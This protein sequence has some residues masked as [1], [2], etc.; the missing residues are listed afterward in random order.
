MIKIDKISF[1]NTIN[2]VISGSKFSGK[3]TLAKHFARMF[4]RNVVY[5]PMKDF[6]KA[7]FENIYV[8]NTN[9]PEEYEIFCANVLRVGNMMMIVDEAQNF[10]PGGNK[11]L[12]PSAFQIVMHGRHNGIGLMTTTKRPALLSKTVFEEANY[13]F[14]FRHMIPNDI[15]YLQEIVGEDAWI[16]QYLNNYRFMIYNNSG[17]EQTGSFSGPY[18]LVGDRIIEDKDDKLNQDMSYIANIAEECIS[19]LRKK[20]VKGLLSRAN[21]DVFLKIKDVNLLPGTADLIYKYANTM[22]KS[23]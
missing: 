9:M 20:G 12:T 18:M 11:L 14:L 5:D 22:S 2:I 23:R 19:W 3:S 4:L 10:M 6:Q 21:V 7:G 15:E 16:L 1:H 8:P 17:D 13:L